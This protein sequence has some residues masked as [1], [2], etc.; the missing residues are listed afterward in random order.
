MLL[1]HHNT[2]YAVSA[3]LPDTFAE[4]A[5]IAFVKKVFYKFGVPDILGCHMAF[6]WVTEM[7]KNAYK[8]LQIFEETLS[9]YHPQ[10]SAL[11]EKTNGTIMQMLQMILEDWYV[12]LDGVLV[13]TS[14]DENFQKIHSI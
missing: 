12:L 2:Q 9:S 10:T 5:E 4:V 3:A 13:L 1:L 8:R 14:Q 11:V 7:L 6:Y